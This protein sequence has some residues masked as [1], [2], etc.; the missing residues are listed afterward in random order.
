MDV[1]QLRD[2]APLAIHYF[3]HPFLAA[4]RQMACGCQRNLVALPVQENVTLE[5]VTLRKSL[6]HAAPEKPAAIE[7]D[8]VDDA[9]AKIFHKMLEEQLS[10][11]KNDL[12]S[13]VIGRTQRADA[14]AQKAKVDAANVRSSVLQMHAE[15]RAARET[16]RQKQ[17]Q[18]ERL[19]S[20]YEMLRKVEKEAASYATAKREEAWKAVWENSAQVNAQKMAEAQ[21]YGRVW[22]SHR[23][24]LNVCVHLFWLRIRGTKQCAVAFCQDL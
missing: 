1:T 2:P 8:S 19:T 11:I 3:M 10:V 4:I 5:N 22:T 18:L 7:E 24:F 23:V 17:A 6:T 16:A 21:R 12:K 20:Q 14:A 13:A 9:T 15:S